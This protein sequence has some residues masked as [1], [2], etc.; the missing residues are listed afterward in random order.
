[1]ENS[2]PAFANNG[3]IAIFKGTA[4]DYV[5]ETNG[6]SFVD[7]LISRGFTCY[8]DVCQK[9]NPHTGIINAYAE[10]ADSIDAGFTERDYVGY[11]ELYG[12]A[13]FS[14]SLVDTIFPPVNGRKAG[15]Y[16]VKEY[17]VDLTAEFTSYAANL[18]S[19]YG[20]TYD[21]DID[22]AYKDAGDFVYAFGIVN[23]QKAAWVV[24]REDLYYSYQDKMAII[25]LF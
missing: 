6:N 19:S 24:L 9:P 25:S 11:V 3:Y 2:F 23:G 7:A 12:M 1:V 8:L 15:V 4:Y 10:A 20:F 21:S 22:G 18:I 17:A 5:S 16:I 13:D 14:A